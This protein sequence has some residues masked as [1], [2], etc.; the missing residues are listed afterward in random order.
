MVNGN[1]TMKFRCHSLC[2]VPLQALHIALCGILARLCTVGDAMS[3][4][5]VSLAYMDPPELYLDRWTLS[6]ALLTR[7]H[8]RPTWFWGIVV[9]G[10]AS[11]ST[12]AILMAV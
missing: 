3:S 4:H 9:N 10:S 12:A 7:R 1:V 6:D 5:L 11:Q 8:T 2:G